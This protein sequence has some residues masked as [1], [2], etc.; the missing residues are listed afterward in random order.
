MDTAFVGRQ[1][2]Y[3]SRLELFAYELLYRRDHNNVATFADAEQATS[4]II[5]NTFMEIGLENIVGSRLAFINVTGEF[6][7]GHYP[8]PMTNEQVVLEVLEDTRPEPDVIEGMREL[9]E[10]GYQLALDDFVLQPEC[11]QFLDFATFVKLDILALGRDELAR[12]IPTLRKRGVRLIAEKVETLTDY[13][14]CKEFGF[15]YYQ[16]FFFSQPD[17]VHAPTNPSNRSVIIS[18]ISQLQNPDIDLAKLEQL[19]AQDTVLSYRL[20]RYINCATFALRREVESIQ[21]AIML[22]GLAAVRK[23]ATLLL[24]SQSGNEKPQQLAVM[25]LVRANMCE[26]LS[27]RLENVSGEQAF[28]VGLFSLLDA[29]LDTPMV[30]LLD[31]MPLSMPIKMALL[32]R[33]GPLGRLI[34][35]VVRYERGDWAELSDKEIRPADYRM[36]YLTAVR[37]ADESAKLLL[38]V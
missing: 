33:E 29:I 6:F 35:D 38:A 10:R 31:Q 37:W 21:Q 13:A 1:P 34:E 30:E 18:L 12:V 20:L 4:E 22:L 16:G 7:T 9:T 36:A 8:L 19:I 32:E 5:V 25:S 28:T 3:D 24:M 23:W 15:D 14:M 17:I 27:Q 2:I 26:L 11:M